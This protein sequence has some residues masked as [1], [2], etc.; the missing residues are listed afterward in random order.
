MKIT[1]WGDFP[2]KVGVQRVRKEDGDAMVTA[3]NSLRGRLARAWRGV[4]VFV[5]HPDV[6]PTNYPDKRR[7]GKI[8]D[9]QS[10][11]DGLY[12]LIEMNDLGDQ[13]MN[14]GHYLYCSPTWELKR[15]GRFVR[16]ID[17]ISVGLTNTPNI[18]G[19]P[20]ANNEAKNDT[21]MKDI[22]VKLLRAAGLVAANA[23]DAAIEAAANEVLN[24]QPKG[25]FLVIG[26]NESDLGNR[27]RA[28]LNKLNADRPEGEADASLED[29]AKA[30]GVEPA[31]LQQI[32]SG[33]VEAP[34][35][36]GLQGFA[37][38][39]GVPVT[40]LTGEAADNADAEG[41]EGDAKGGDDSEEDEEEEETNDDEAM[42][43]ANDR[44]Q[45]ERQGR[46]LLA[47]NAAIA[48]GRVTEAERQKWTDQ[49]TA[50]EDFE[51]VLTAM[52]EQEIKVVQKSQ[53]D[54]LGKRKGEAAGLIS[55]NE[56]V[57]TYAKENGI[58]IGTN[59]GWNQAFAATKKKHPELFEK[60]TA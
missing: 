42:K 45:A 11:E 52:N 27:L 7:Y 9:L 25:R 8:T 24:R 46:A 51:Q 58:D 21:A 12:G 29:L 43:Q 41:G 53:V 60:K 56:A 55:I 54:D 47:V 18:P 32:L 49:L 23:D 19:E 17:L 15:D 36:E 13:A 59:G 33:E 6:D 39:L 28:A 31:T 34:S 37:D 35:A 10:R 1:P 38:F 48:A 22:L 2:N 5:G 3:F 40:D 20:W 44:I 57:T 16:P 26:Y 14:E 30:G 4:S 50:A